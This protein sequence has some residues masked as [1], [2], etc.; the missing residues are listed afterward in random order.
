MCRYGD[1][2]VPTA[3]SDLHYT[4]WYSYS[5]FQ[6]LLHS[7]IT[8]VVMCV[9]VHMR[10]TMANNMRRMCIRYSKMHTQKCSYI[11]ILKIIKSNL[12]ISASVSFGNFNASYMK[13]KSPWLK[14]DH[15]VLAEKRSHAVSTLTFNV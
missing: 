14:P 11:I 10:V 1:H 3:V 9:C 7:L 5:F 6:S 2:M 12:A 8:T 13:I 4:Q 15:D